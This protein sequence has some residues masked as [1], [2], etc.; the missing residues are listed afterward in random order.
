MIDD[1]GKGAYA[2]IFLILTGFAVAGGAF[3]VV[4]L[5]YVKRRRKAEQVG[6]TPS[7]PTPVPS[8]EEAAE[9]AAAAKSAFDSKKDSDKG[10]AWSSHAE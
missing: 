2:E 9:P 10:S 1:Q 4:L 3:A 6:S 8:Y 5:W 7:E